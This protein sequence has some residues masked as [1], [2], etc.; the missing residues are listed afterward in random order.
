M[1]ASVADGVGVNQKAVKSGNSSGALPPGVR[2]M[3]R[4]DKPTWPS[5]PLARK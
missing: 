4:A 2:A 5:S 1:T 3:P